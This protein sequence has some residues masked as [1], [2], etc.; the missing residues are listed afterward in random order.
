MVEKKTKRNYVLLQKGEHYF[1]GKK[2][3]DGDSVRVQRE[4]HAE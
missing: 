4:G 1:L 2:K 3:G